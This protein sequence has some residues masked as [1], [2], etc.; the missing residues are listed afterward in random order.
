MQTTQKRRGTQQQGIA[1]IVVL[2][3][4][5]MLVTLAV[6]FAI[7]M[8]IERMASNAQIE[9]VKARNL[10]WTALTRAV[11]QMEQEMGPGQSN[12]FYHGGC[13]VA[14]TG[15]I[16]DPD[17]IQRLAPM[18]PRDTRHPTVYNLTINSSWADVV[19]Q[20]DNKLLGQY[21]FACVDC[22]G[23]LDV[24]A[25]GTRPRAYGVDP[26]EISFPT[27]L[28]S[29]KPIITDVDAFK[30]ERAK[31]RL[32]SGFE[33]M[34]RLGPYM[35]S[36]TNNIMWNHFSYFPNDR[37]I[38]WG[39]VNSKPRVYIG[40]NAAQIA[41]AKSDIMSAAAN[42]TGADTQAFYDNLYDMVNSSTDIPTNPN[43]MGGGKLVPMLYEFVATNYV[44]QISGGKGWKNTVAL[45]F[46]TWFP[47]PVTANKTYAIS[48]ASAPTIN[49][50]TAPALTP[51]FTPQ[52]P[53]V[54][55]LISTPTNSF[56][57]NTFTY[58]YQTT[59][60]NALTSVTTTITLPA[61]IYVRSGSSAGAVV[62]QMP[63]PVAGITFRATPNARVVAQGWGVI[64]PRINYRV[65]DWKPHSADPLIGTPQLGQTNEFCNTV[66]PTP[67]TG[68][69]TNGDGSTFMYTYPPVIE[70]LQS[71]GDMGY[72]LYD[73]DKPW[74]T[75]RLFNPDPD[76]TTRIFDVLAILPTNQY[77]QGF[78]NPNHGGF[79]YNPNLL[80][81]SKTTLGCVF[82]NAPTGRYPRES[83][84]SANRVAGDEA[85]DLAN[86]LRSGWK[87]D[88]V[89]TNISDICRLSAANLANV[90]PG[91]DFWQQKAVMRNSIG[92]FNPRQNL[93]VIAING[94]GIKKGPGSP[95]TGFD[96]LRDVETSIC[97]VVAVVWRDPYPDNN[98]RHKCFPQFIQ[99]TRF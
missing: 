82:A 16:T 67:V 77:Y 98:G 4:L 33:I 13:I 78:L 54:P 39:T 5:A 70:S 65:S 96:P 75:V 95:P 22:S 87:N 94:R 32:E 60:T 68:V 45:I 30:T 49:I 50:A 71:I 92:L 36:P 62:D 56:W 38:D 47:F 55:G 15:G 44:E 80:I 8:R 20:R 85:M 59:D 40:T 10:M 43:E 12:T 51:A 79:T 1:L 48:L 27:N 76:H 3:L 26:G 6:S 93:W 64:D 52:A 53:V 24:N 14:K 89:F 18:F 99:W 9:D 11:L 69:A 83:G 57:T 46:E 84:E 73:P 23:Y 74:H 42:M 66:S 63:A 91:L 28:P 58:V 29:G 72:L 90:F 35:D 37:Y 31:H 86:I 34:L 19:D 41:Q 81:I 25:V 21:Q 17:L 97:P 7:S 2:S 61:A 88:N